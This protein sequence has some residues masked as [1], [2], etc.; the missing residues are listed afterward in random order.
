[1]KRSIAILLS[2]LLLLSI[3]AAAFADA[4]EVTW[5]MAGA[6][7]TVMNQVNELEAGPCF[8]ATGIK[9]IPKIYADR[10]TFPIEV[11]GGAGPDIMDL[12]GPTDVVE[13]IKAGQVYDLTPYIE[14]YGWADKFMDW[15]LESCSYAGVVYSLPTSY[16]GMGL[17]YNVD[18]MKEHGWEIPNSLA[19]LEALFDEILAAGLTPVS[20]GNSNYQG[21]VDWLYS[22]FLS[23]YAGGTKNIKAVLEGEGT[24]YSNEG[25]RAAVQRLVDWYAKGYI[26]NNSTG[27]STDDMI[28][29]FAFGDAVTMIDGTWGMN[30]L[31]VDYPDCNWTFELMP[32]EVE[33]EPAIF[34]IAVGG[35]AAINGNCK[36]PE[37]A[38][39][40][41]NFRFFENE[42]NCYINMVKNGAQPFPVLWFDSAKLEGLDPKLIHA[43]DVMN[44]A[45]AAGNVGY[46]SWTFY[47]ADCRVYMNENTDTIFL[48]LMSVEDYLNGAQAYIDEAIA[49]GV[50]PVVP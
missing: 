30:A 36:N 3:S 33:G 50:S 32:P 44:E 35:A 10:T 11:A 41:M 37:E 43:Y 21:A 27:I 46:C 9:F 48:G 40:V 15:A 18:V 47:P 49:T 19:G 20:F 2:V 12:D 34:P 22:T 31:T 17:Y 29:R 42:D 45:M 13:F 25:T 6:T 14:E 38:A 4:G 39:K 28:A 1:M 26:D 8:E 16:E 5:G 24:L 7:E 23:C